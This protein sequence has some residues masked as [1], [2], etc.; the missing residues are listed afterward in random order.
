[1]VQLADDELQLIADAKPTKTVFIGFASAAADVFD[2]FDAFTSVDASLRLFW[3]CVK[4]PA[5][6]GQVLPTHYSKARDWR[7]AA[8]LKKPDAPSA[9]AIDVRYGSHPRR[10]WQKR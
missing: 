2:V 7:S 1:M 5:G 6:A 9:L 4:R 10:T 8:V 3:R